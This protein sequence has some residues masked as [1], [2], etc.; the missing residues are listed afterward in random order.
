MRLVFVYNMDLGRGDIDVGD[1]SPEQ[2]ERWIRSLSRFGEVS[3][4]ELMDPM[5]VLRELSGAGA[6][7]QR[8]DLVVNMSE[9]RLGTYKEALVPMFCD[10]LALPHTLSDARGFMLTQDKALAKREV[11]KLGVMKVPQGVTVSDRDIKDGLATAVGLRYP[12]IVKPVYNGASEGIYAD[13]VVEDAENLERKVREL[14]SDWPGTVMVEEYIR[15]VDIFVP[16]LE[17]FR[18]SDAHGVPHQE[19]L[20]PY[21]IYVDKEHLGDR[22]YFT[23]DFEFKTTFDHLVQV[24]T[25]LAFPRHV[26]EDIR[27]RC[28]AIYRGLD[29]RDVGRI[30]LRVTEDGTPYFLELN[31]M[32]A[33]AEGGEFEQAAHQRG[34]L[35][36]DGVIGAIVQS[37][38][39]RHGIPVEARVAERATVG[40]V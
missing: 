25:P 21:E 33:L 34:G 18:G 28:A 32:P 13:S 38:M 24:R 1:D 12:L 8:P 26:I 27:A 22:K 2:V 17:Y 39:R 7:G 36:Y 3:A 15:G 29:I 35:D 31:A 10:A 37:A 19:V 6:S 16:Y 40:S 11:E 14:L 9:A 30:D 4:V 5:D 20:E 23:Y